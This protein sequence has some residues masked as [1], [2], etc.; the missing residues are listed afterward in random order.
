[1]QSA[2]VGISLGPFKHQLEGMAE[3][4]QH[5]PGASPLYS[6]AGIT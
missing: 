1:M 6:I 4:N 3:H 5:D 2:L